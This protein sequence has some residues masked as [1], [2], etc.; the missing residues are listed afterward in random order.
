MIKA[1]FA[2]LSLQAIAHDHFPKDIKRFLIGGSIT[3][4]HDFDDKWD[5]LASIYRSSQVDNRSI[6][7]F[8]IGGRYRLHPNLKV[9]LFYLNEWGHREDDDWLET[10]PSS[11][12]WFWRDV[13]SVHLDIIE[14]E[15]YPRFMLDFLPGQRWILELR[16]SHQT[17]LHTGM[18]L[19]H[20]RPGL[21]YFWFKKGSPFINFSLRYGQ[22]NRLSLKNGITKYRKEV[23]FNTLYHYSSNLKFNVNITHGKLYW[24]P[25]KDFELDS[26][27]EIYEYVEELTQII[28]GLV[29]KI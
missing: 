2:F 26:P 10:T 19:L 9:G 28:F 20:F 5:G 1:L 17:K 16:T 25:S 22:Y 21:T 14:A 24:G 12:I 29:F 13:D 4:I 15:V 8:R 23:Y 3:A 11:D 27:N 6:G 7:Q 18:R